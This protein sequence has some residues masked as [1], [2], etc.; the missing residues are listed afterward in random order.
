MPLSTFLNLPPAIV[1]AIAS[2]LKLYQIISTPIVDQYLLGSRELSLIH[3]HLEMS[4]A[5]WLVSKCWASACQNF[6]TLVF[7]VFTGVSL[8]KIAIHQ[9]SCECFGTFEV[10]PWF[11]LVVDALMVYSLINWKTALLGKARSTKRWV[12]AWI[13]ISIFIW[14]CPLF[15]RPVHVGEIGK[16]VGNS[17]TI[18]VEPKTWIHKPLPISG[19]LESVPPAMNGDWLIILVNAECQTCNEFV[20]KLNTE[21]ITNVLLVE[22][23]AYRKAFNTDSR[24]PKSFPVAKVSDTFDWFVKAPVVIRLHDGVVSSVWVP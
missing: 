10:S 23:P 20:D 9:K 18:L 14:I 17:N 1:L 13:A 24:W 3:I 19:Y 5:C 8:F 7:V 6:A 22:F 11:S 15:T 16:S 2:L 12:S 4:L 21:Q